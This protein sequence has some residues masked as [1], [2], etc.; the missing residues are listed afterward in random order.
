MQDKKSSA[1][2]G[3]PYG[4]KE[5]FQQVIKV[6]FSAFVRTAKRDSDGAGVRVDEIL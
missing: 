2:K 6:M 1:H 5:L 4:Q 3:K